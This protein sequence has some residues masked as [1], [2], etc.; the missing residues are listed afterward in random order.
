MYEHFWFQERPFLNI[1]CKVVFIPPSNISFL[2]KKNV[3]FVVI[4]WQL[5]IGSKNVH[6]PKCFKLCTRYCG[7]V[8]PALKNFS[9]RKSINTPLFNGKLHIQNV[10]IKW[11]I[12]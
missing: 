9:K 2:Q 3:K 4:K 7:Y 8:F 5:S 11:D 10:Q 1:K 6:M 12:F